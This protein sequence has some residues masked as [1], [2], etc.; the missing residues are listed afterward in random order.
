MG[1]RNSTVL[2]YVECGVKCDVECKLALV[3]IRAKCKCLSPRYEYIALFASVYC[4]V[5]HCTAPMEN[6]VVLSRSDS[7]HAYQLV[8]NRALEHHIHI[9]LKHVV[10]RCTIAAQ[11]C[12]RR[13]GSPPKQSNSN[14]RKIFFPLTRKFH[15]NTLV[16]PLLR[17]RVLV[18]TRRERPNAE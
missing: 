15:S 14:P 16:L 13:R 12:Q 11:Q 2:L 3:C 8:T 9:P 6:S 4:T 5:L 18:K 17:L 1:C 7:A 10:G